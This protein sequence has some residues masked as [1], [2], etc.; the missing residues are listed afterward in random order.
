MNSELEIPVSLV[1]FVGR[2]KVKR[3][4]LGD[5]LPEFGPSVGVDT[6]T[7][8]ISDTR[9]VPPLVVLGVFD[10][11]ASTCWIV[12]W[13]SA[14][15]FMKHL[16]SLDVEQRYF[17]LGFD[18]QVLSAEDPDCGLL[19]AIDQGR[20]V[21]MQIRLHLHEI[22][23]TGF[24]R[25][26]MHS[27][28][29]CVAHYENWHLD[30]GDGTENSARLS[31]K[32]QNLDGT[33]RQLTDEQL[34][35]LPMDCISTWCLGEAVPS[36]PTEI[37]HTKG[38][39]VLAHM[40]SN[41]VQVDQKMFDYFDKKLRDER[42]KHREA[43]LAYGF[44]DPD[45]DAQEEALKVR[46]AFFSTYSELL[47]LAGL[48]SELQVTD[49]D[50]KMPGKG[51]L[52]L[53]L[54]YIYAHEDEPSE[55]KDMASHV[56]IVLEGARS[57]LRKNET[58]LY[59]QLCEDYGIESV[60]RCSKAVA[61]QAYVWK[62]M[63]S[64][65]LQLRE[66]SSY[67]FQVCCEHADSYMD[68][69][70]GLMKPTATEGPR[71]FFQRHAKEVLE[72]N[73]KLELETTEKS[74][75]IKLT[76]KDLWRL[77]DV[78]VTDNFL[79]E[80]AAYNHCVKYLS[81]YMRRDFIKPDGRVHPRYTNILRTSRTS[82]NSPNIQQLPSRD[83]SF[84]LKLLYRSYPGMVLCSTDYS[85]IELCAFAQACYSRFGYSVMRDVINTGL[86]PHRWFAGVMTKAI[87]PDLTHANDPQ[88]VA[89]TKAFL[90]ANVTKESRQR[91]K[92]ANFG[93]I[94]KVS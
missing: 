47:E 7:E 63:E 18:E 72:R 37:A 51:Q 68:S 8:L 89:E 23:T 73:P 69:H 1:H 12:E 32:R 13:D 84:A 21:D 14:P 57:T 92:F 26:D 90:E 82:C 70:P 61:L 3:W 87:T 55:T 29:G 67:S 93:G 15:A 5:P 39:C 76:T 17:N 45:Y 20:V 44:P 49:G 94:K 77:E 36:M 25:Y 31:F 60:D 11:K 79:T 33:R 46:Q 58:T 52:K 16:C 48:Q 80:Y 78:G 86:D 83:K 24:I 10:P 41:G 50:P 38:M 34:K 19:T 91:A 88:W 59:G 56:K 74:G 54:M 35:Y 28:A 53:G 40:S 4:K 75:E 71:K 64:A 22:A 62:L 30:K 27:L 2:V 9:P 65:L 42:N 85:F 66:K 81:T 43:L 6:E